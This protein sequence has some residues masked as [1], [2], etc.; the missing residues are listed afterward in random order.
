MGSKFMVSLAMAAA[1][2]GSIAIS[3]DAEADPGGNSVTTC[4]PFQPYPGVTHQRCTTYFYDGN[5]VLL[6]TSVYYIDENGMW[7]IL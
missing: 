1:L 5:G 7:Y 3:G 2:A 6:G 4:E